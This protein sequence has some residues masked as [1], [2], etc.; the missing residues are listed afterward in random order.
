MASPT[1]QTVVAP[2]ID[3]TWT[4]ASV[5]AAVESGLVAAL[6][7]PRTLAELGA[8]TAA[9][10]DMLLRL[11][12][13]LASVGVVTVQGEVVTPDAALATL[14]GD[15][16]ALHVLRDDLRRSLGQPRALV[17]DA[18]SGLL[19]TAWHHTDLDVIEAQGTFARVHT[20]VLMVDGIV[21]ELPG[22]AARLAEPGARALDVGAGAAGNA[23]GFCQAWPALSVLGLEPWPASLACGLANVT[24][25][26][27]DARIEL[28]AQRIEELTERAAFDLIWL[29]Q[30]FLDDAT[31]ARALELCGRAL[32]P[33]GWLLTAWICDDRPGLPAALLRLRDV[34]FGGRARDADRVA[35]ALVDA[36]YLDVQRKAFAGGSVGMVAGRYGR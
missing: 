34:A 17:A 23:I 20:R 4:L 22:L 2:L 9:S 32:R 33:G 29:P 27:L 1:L 36:G 21:P 28:R 30:M 16:Q 3:A 8:E 10:P 24:A 35:T 13:V 19:G 12:D 14:A 5:S 7:R 31:L 26:G 11:L 25:A 15:A 6:T 18:R